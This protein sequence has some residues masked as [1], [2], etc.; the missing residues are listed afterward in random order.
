MGDTGEGS[1]ER[2]AILT[3]LFKGLNRI[4]IVNT[5]IF[6]NDNTLTVQFLTGLGKI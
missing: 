3:C 4:I 6:S 2:F 5:G 1:Q